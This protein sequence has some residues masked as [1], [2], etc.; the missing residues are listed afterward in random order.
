VWNAPSY[1]DRFYIR[2]GTFHAPYKRGKFLNRST[3]GLIAVRHD[4]GSL[5][6]TRRA[7][8]SELSITI[9][10][11]YHNLENIDYVVSECHHLHGLPDHRFVGMD[12]FC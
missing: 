12:G 7:V 4:D 9:M 8:L 1:G 2:A 5:A 10:R 3:L 6:V 11:S